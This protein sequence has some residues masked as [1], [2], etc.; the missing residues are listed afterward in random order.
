MNVFRQAGHDVRLEW[1]AEGVAA[2]G[3]GCAVLVVVDVLSFS[4]RVDLALAEGHRVRP[5]HWLGEDPPEGT[6]VPLRSPNGAT[7]SAEAAATGAHVLTACLRNAHAVAEAALA[8]AG[9]APVGVV[10]CGERWG[11]HLRAGP[12][13]TGPLRPCVEDHLGAGA[14]VAAL[15]D[16]GARRLSP[17]ASLAALAWRAAGP[18]A[19]ALVAGSA[20]GREL[21]ENGHGGLVGHAVAVGSSRVVPRLRE[22]VYERG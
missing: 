7:L 2:L 22:G 16:L 3:A 14:V 18:E 13:A 9:D 21:R 20:S 11:V 19:G 4:T 5:V 1:G 10:P 12:G 8:L 17:E 15:L 6:E